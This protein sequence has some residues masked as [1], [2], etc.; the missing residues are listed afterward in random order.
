VY[1]PGWLEDNNPTRSARV[2][3][4]AWGGLLLPYVEQAPLYARFDLK[5]PISFGTYGGA[6]ENID[7]VATPLPLYRCPSDA[8][9]PEYGTFGGQSGFYPPVPEMATS[10]YVGSA[11]LC[12]AC[13]NSH[14]LIG[15]TSN[16]CPTGPAGVLFR[17]SEISTAHIT[18]GTSQ[19]FLIGERN[20]IGDG[21]GPYWAGPPGPVSNQ[22]ACFGSLMTAY[23]RGSQNES[24]LPFLNGHGDGFSSQHPSVIQVLMCDGAVRPLKDDIDIVTVASLIQINDGKVIDSTA[25]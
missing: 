19:T 22:L 16:N 18:D 2:P 17:N 1:A 12:D 15:E 21:R 8:E 7:L 11:S 4:F 25:Y 5:K 23:L 6:V 3:H 10:N 24:A 20:F 13:N 9:R 14:L